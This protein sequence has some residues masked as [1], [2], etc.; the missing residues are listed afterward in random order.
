MLQYVILTLRKSH[1]AQVV[2]F[3]SGIVMMVQQID[4]QNGIS[5]NTLVAALPIVPKNLEIGPQAGIVRRLEVT[6]D[7]ERG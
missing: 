6:V 7:A 1:V 2:C 4:V 3:K 5:S